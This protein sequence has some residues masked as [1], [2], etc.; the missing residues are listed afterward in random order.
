MKDS[1]FFKNIVAVLL[2]QGGNYIIPLLSFPYLTRTLGVENYGIYGLAMTMSQYLM[3]FVDFGFGLSSS[4]NIAINRN[5]KEV[6]GQVI[7]NTITIKA[8]VSISLVIIVV[9]LCAMFNNIYSKIA[10]ILMLQCMS[11][12]FNFNWLYQGLEKVRVFVWLTLI[13]KT[14]SLC[15]IFLCVRGS[16]DF[17]LAIFV[18]SLSIFLLAIL[19]LF[20]LVVMMKGLGIKL[21]LPKMDGLKITFHETKHYFIAN[22]A[23]SMYTASTPIILSVF[24]NNS[25]VGIFAS[26]DRIKSAILGF[27]MVLSGVLYPKLNYLFEKNKPKAYSLFK[28]V[29]LTETILTFIISVSLYFL[30][31]EICIYIMG[32]EFHDGYKVLQMLSIVLFLSMQSVMMSN[33]LLL[34]LGYRNLYSKLPMFIS[35]L[36]VFLSAFSVKYYGVLGAAYSIVFLELFVCVIY[37]IYIYKKGIFSNLINSSLK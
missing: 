8:L 11:A 35:V 7:V 5:K 21:S 20:H 19:S 22:V 30:S 10:L 18:Q 28:K 33:Y 2:L 3:L 9:V 24:S 27:F 31:K 1:N 4:R 16:E 25:S 15:L 37:I 6:I 14:V 12:I 34:P 36:H 29:Y 26:S 23:I 17:L 32:D 13:S